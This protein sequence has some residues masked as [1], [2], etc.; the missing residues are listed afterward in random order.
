MF[1]LCVGLSKTFETKVLACLIL[2]IQVV[3]FGAN[4]VK[5][6][7]YKVTYIQVLI[8]WEVSLFIDA[9]LII[10]VV[11]SQS[12]SSGVGIALIFKNLIF[13][14]FLLLTALINPSIQFIWSLKA[15][16]T[17]LEDHS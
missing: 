15:K 11:F 3:S 16:K 7:T 14:I 17:P 8:F 4:L 12:T 6:Y 2:A 1:A 13:S 9:V 10:Y 5:F